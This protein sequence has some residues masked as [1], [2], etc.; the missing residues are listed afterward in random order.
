MLRK[1]FCTLLQ[2]SKE[3]SGSNNTIM[4]YQN[5]VN[6]YQIPKRKEKP[7][8]LPGKENGAVVEMKIK[9]HTV[10]KGGTKRLASDCEI[11]VA[12]KQKTMV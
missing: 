6:T 9:E 7:V 1:P 4:K 10:K 8:V 3:V 11:C 12:K 2:A 5:L